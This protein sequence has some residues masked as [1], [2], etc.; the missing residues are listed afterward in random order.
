[1]Y[2][3]G[4]KVLTFELQT[5]RQFFPQLHT[6]VTGNT[7]HGFSGVTRTQIVPPTSASTSSSLVHDQA[8]TPVTVHVAVRIISSNYY[9]RPVNANAL[10][11]KRSKAIII[12]I[13]TK[14]SNFYTV[15]VS[16]MSI[17]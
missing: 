3:R 2:V 7:V 6:L 16:I 1:M 13:R 12:Q 17:P 9:A 5:S 4:I 14:L 11:Y 10:V 15:Y 8:W